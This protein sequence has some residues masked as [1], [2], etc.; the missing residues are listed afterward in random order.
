MSTTLSFFLIWDCL[1]LMLF[2]TFPKHNIYIYI[3]INFENVLK[4]IN[5]SAIFNIIF[6]STFYNSKILTYSFPTL[7]RFPNVESKR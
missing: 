2:N 4:K 1:H 7:V 6:Y 3:Y 5:I